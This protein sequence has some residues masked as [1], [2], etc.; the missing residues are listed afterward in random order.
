MV[1]HRLKSWL[2]SIFKR[3]AAEND[4]QRELQSHIDLEAE[5]QRE[6]GL[7]AEEAHYAARRA[8]GNPTL[9]AEDV[10]GSWNLAW[11]EHFF[12]DLRHGARSLLGSPSFSAV[13]VLTLA[14]GI[15]ANTAIFS[16]ID[17][18][19]LRPLP[20]SS[21]DQIVRIYS[22]TSGITDTFSNPDGP[23]APDVRDFE[24]KSHSFQKMVI[25]DTWR[26]NV[27]F[28]DSASEPEQMRVGL[29][30]ATYFEILDVKP[31]AG[32]LF[33]EDENQAGRN[34]VAA[35]SSHLWRNRFGGDPAVL[36]RKIRIN[37]EPY[38]IVAVM[39]DVPPE[40]VEAGMVDATDLWTPLTSSDV[41]AETSRG[42][43]GYLALG[44]L[45]PGVSLEQ[46]QA[47]LSVIAD[48]LAA[49]HPVD[50]G[51][52]VSV[53][54]L[55]DTRAGS[56]RPML[57]L[58]MGAV[59]LILLI[60]CVNLANLLLARNSARG[61]E[62]A[63]RAALGSS[64]GGLIRQLLAET[65]LLSLAGAAA[66]LLLAKA[67]L[68]S[69]MMLHPANLSQLESLEID[70][71]V[72][73][74]TLSVSLITAFLFGL[75][76]AITGTRLNLVDALKLGGRSGTAGKRGKRM[77]NL[78]I[79]T[80]MAMSLMLLV[81]ASLVVQSLAR[82][83]RQNLGI[84]QDHLLKGHFYVPRVRYPDAG[85]ITRFCDQFA[86]KVR[87]L[88]GVV[89]ASVTTIYPPNN[90]WTQMLGIPGHTVTR[91]Q[92]IPAAQ[93]GVADAHFRTTLGIPL[94]RGRDFAETDMATSPPVAIITEEFKHRYFPS[95]DPIGQ[96]IHIGPPQFMQLPPGAGVTDSSDVTIVGIIG[97][98]RNNGLALPP[99]PQIVVLYSQHPLVNYGFK[100]IVI[101]TASDPSS[102]APAISRRLHDLDSDMPFAEVQTIEALVEEESGGQ[103]FTAVL[104]SLFA[105]AGLVL[106]IVGIYG[107]VSFVVAQRNQELAVRIALGASRANVLWLVLK[108]GLEMATIGAAVGL[109]GACATQKLTSGLLFGISPVDPAT[110]AGGTA[111]LLAVAVITSAVPGMRVMRIDPSE[112]LRQD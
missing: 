73:A 70:W 25:Y 54:K 14:L 23:S 62:L 88:P 93:F 20:F 1:W 65:L 66:G 80:E 84:R 31:I 19:M 61:R 39:P 46:A 81:T 37:G 67:G 74:F 16:T 71:R 3:Q 56:L 8:F 53:K 103:R 5:E 22:I 10:R 40:R 44:R 11:L 28:V 35:I 69:V 92:D 106:A 24:Q 86:N 29:V 98:F 17:A 18:L 15:G 99:E 96:K 85:A 26:K 108:Q 102:L 105:A 6:Y 101:R 45:K 75:A 79:A 27:T 33:A 112:V 68:A 50:Q 48:A 63:V 38:A 55:A 49:E 36:G 94:I 90:G 83:N 89:D 34:F 100:D 87:A 4:L 52:R 58:L 51:V 77:R 107:V 109:L 41:W 78:L 13:A 97:D 60:A 72:L 30:P 104:L 111:L 110:F 47:D 32:R 12:R 42:E 82:L 76:P 95:Q 2:S 91:I 21:P 57:F 43:R 59:S 64:R 7:P 9:I